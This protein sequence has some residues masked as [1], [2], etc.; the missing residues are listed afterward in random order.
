[1]TLSVN[2]TK[3]SPQQK[4]RKN[5]IK[6]TESSPPI[7]LNLSFPNHL[8][9][10]PKSSLIFGYA[11]HHSN[12]HLSH[13]SLLQI[14]IHAP[15]TSFLKELY[16]VFP[17]LKTIE[18]KSD[19]RSCSNENPEQLFVLPTFQKTFY[20]LVANTPQTQWERNLCYHYF[21]YFASEFVNK[22]KAKGYWADY[23][24]PADGF[25]VKSCRGSI[26]YPDVEGACRLLKYK[27]TQV[28]CC[29]IL[30]H[31][32]WGTKNYPAT[33]FAKAPLA[34]LQEILVNLCQ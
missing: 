18:K 25:P 4:P 7:L 28:G 13:P 19:W 22:L 10:D 24:D 5:N 31:P 14:S 3:S 12:P 20:D 11:P 32:R 29:S 23:T 34:I 33:L 17:E 1:M 9:P 8:D 27:T 6:L 16:L 21:H 26:L 30:L 2:N 15:S